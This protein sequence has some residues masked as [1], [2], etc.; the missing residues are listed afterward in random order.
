[1]PG[2][3]ERQRAVASGLQ[4]IM[5]LNCSCFVNPE[6]CCSYITIY[7]HNGPY[8]VG[9]VPFLQTGAHDVRGLRPEGSL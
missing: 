6:P 1:M 3:V 8:R 5:S 7:A 9:G 4:S 2:E